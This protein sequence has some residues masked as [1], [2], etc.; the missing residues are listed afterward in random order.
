MENE[1]TSYGS[2]IL[3]HQDPDSRQALRI[4]SELKDP[5]VEQDEIT[6]LSE[7]PADPE[8]RYAAILSSIA[9]MLENKLRSFPFQTFLEQ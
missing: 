6:R 3:T 1:G 8:E 4:V 9:I 7:F 5:H 2:F